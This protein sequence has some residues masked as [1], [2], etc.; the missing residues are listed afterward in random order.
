MNSSEMIFINTAYFKLKKNNLFV[1]FGRKRFDR[2]NFI[3]S[4]GSLIE[5][6][7]AIPIPKVSFGIDQYHEVE[8]GKIQF[9]LKGNFAHGWLDKGQYIK[10]PFLHEKSLYLKKNLFDGYS[11]SFGLAHKA[12][13][14]GETIIHGKQPGGIKDFIRV[15]FARPGS[16]KSIAQEKE[17][18]LGNHLGI[19]DFSIEKEYNNKLI[20]IYLEH[21]FED[22]SS[23]RWIL[24]EF[25][26][27]YGISVSQKKSNL[28]SNFVYE[29]LN[30]MDQSGKEGASDSTYGWD[31]YYNHYIYQSGW[32]YYGR[33]IGNPLFTLGSNKGRYSDGIYIINNRIK[34]HHIGLSGSFIKNI[35]YRIL[36]TYSE[37][38]GIFPD[39]NY[40]DSIKQDYV[41]NGGLVQRSGMIE[42]LYN[43]VWRRLD[44]TLAYGIDNGDLLNKTDSFMIKIDYKLKL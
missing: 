25:D 10:A 33:I 16:E 18:T 2:D 38:Y 21:P 15:F 17:N 26:G 31:N 13:W 19:W 40:Y 41:F 39:E 37:N 20:K 9:S 7:N 24:N 44:L 1:S 8:F 3:L 11:F 43:D 34:A 5:S 36:Y 23:A 12:L 14:A 27:K 32:T 4:S 29:Y 35:N 42:L 6:T 30:T 22:E 28:L